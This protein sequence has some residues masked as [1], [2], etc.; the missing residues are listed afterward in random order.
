[1]DLDQAVES[2]ARDIRSLRND[3]R[4]NDRQRLTSLELER[5]QEINALEEH[6]ARLVAIIR[7]RDTD[8]V[9]LKALK[10]SSAAEFEVRIQRMKDQGQRLQKKL[11][12]VERDAQKQKQDFQTGERELRQEL[13]ATKQ[14]V[15]T[16]RENF[17]T[18]EQQIRD[19]A[20]QNVEQARNEAAETKAS[21]QQCKEQLRNA[22]ATSESLHE[23]L[24]Q[25]HHK[26]EDDL[27]SAREEL[28]NTIRDRELQNN[29]LQEQL[30]VTQ[31][32]FAEPTV[33]AP[34]EFRRIRGSR[35]TSIS[36]TQQLIMRIFTRH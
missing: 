10:E 12:D 22:A 2:F 18:R 25:Q 35:I 7:Q 34:W 11:Q 1:M 23:E 19:Q 27:R 32:K 20:S 17:E 24:R 16:Q 4:S 30:R 33:N 29:D 36:A 15:Q 5:Q 3:H 28:N 31:Q 21:E 14:A 9:K 26:H 8:V 6:T 13:Q